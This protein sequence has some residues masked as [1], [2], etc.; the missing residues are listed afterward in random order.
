MQILIA[1]RLIS[2]KFPLRKQEISCSLLK[3]FIMSNPNILLVDDEA[4]NRD[5]LSRR[6]VRDNFNVVTASSGQEALDL[7][8]SQ[9]FDIVLLDVMMPGMSGID[10][11]EK[12]RADADPN[13]SG[14]AIIMVSAVSDSSKIV[15][16]LDKGANDYVTKP[17][18]L[19]VLKARIQSQLA[20]S[21]AKAP[22]EP[23]P[24]VQIGSYTITDYIGAGGMAKVFKAKDDR[25]GRDVAIKFLA[26]KNDEEQLQRFIREAKMCAKI[27][28]HG[29]VAVYDTGSTP[30]YYIVMEYIKGRSL[31]K[32]INNQ[33]L[34]VGEAVR[35][36]RQIADALAAVHAQGVLHRDLKPEN[37]L[38]DDDNVVHLTDFGLAKSVEVDVRLTKTGSIMGTPKYMAPDQINGPV[39]PYTDL[40]VLGLL[41]FEMLTG[42][43]AMNG[44]NLMQLCVE[45]MTRIPEPPSKYNIEVP[46]SL[47]KICLKLQARDIAE[48]YQTAEELLA[49]LPSF[50]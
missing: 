12:V 43:P 44:E 38:I 40:Y 35:Y 1:I 45:A 39:G 41:M 23:K 30:C 17:V 9:P 48:R 47:D 8:K 49:D 32:I 3:Y 29:V 33:P 46:E 31:D 2:I 5:V 19:P 26:A 24:G 28:H 6:L 20:Q 11:V 7:L 50:D 37:L 22:F 27:N 4:M 10:V 36:V 14:I 18:N 13:I 16:A 21:R 34:P 15:E 42:K 25:L